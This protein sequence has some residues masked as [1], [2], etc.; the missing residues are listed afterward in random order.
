M[1]KLSAGAVLL[2]LLLTAAA[3][4]EEDGV[5]IFLKAI[6][7]EGP[8][9]LKTGNIV[10]DMSWEFGRK[11]EEEIQ[12]ICETEIA[13]QKEQFARDKERYPEDPIEE[14][15]EEKITAE[16]HARYTKHFLSG[17][18]RFDHSQKGCRYI[19]AEPNSF[20]MPGTVAIEIDYLRG[21]DGGGPKF[22]SMI[23]DPSHSMIIV[24]N[25]RMCCIG[26]FPRFGRVAG[27]LA[28]ACAARAAEKGEPV[29][30]DDIQERLKQIYRCDGPFTVLRIARTEPYEDGSKAYILENAVD[31]KVIERYTIVPSMG[32]LCPKIEIFD[33]VTGHLSQTYE[34]ERFVK[35]SRAD[36]RYPLVYTHS[37]WNT[38]TG[39]WA[40][41]LDY[42]IDEK[43]LSLNKPMKRGD[44]TLKVPKGYCIDDLRQMMN[45][46]SIAVRKGAFKLKPGFTDLEQYSWLKKQDD[47]RDSDLS[48]TLPPL[49]RKILITAGAAIVIAAL[50]VRRRETQKRASA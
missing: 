41:K 31:D 33:P 48:R 10:F 45:D 30:S 40:L 6:D 35:P 16:I 47:L 43:K 17:Y 1:I 3:A 9:V 7:P 20:M 2:A 4:A 11:T 50:V 34:A 15:D 42:T 26:D 38:S 27:R 32:Y 14:P 18:Y 13:R 5:D 49:V 8:S 19:K 37:Y 29:T 36:I 46:C 22:E 24:E 28:D 39:K 25:Q 21:T 44:F 12:T 23:D